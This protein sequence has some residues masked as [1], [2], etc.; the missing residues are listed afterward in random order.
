MHGILLDIDGT[1]LL[2][3]DPLPGAHE[4][5]RWLRDESRP[6]CWLTNNTSMSRRGWLERLAAAGLDPQPNEVYTAGDATIDHLLSR[7]PV[8]RVYL[9]GTDDLRADFDAAAIPLDEE[10]P[11]VVVLGYDTSLTYAKL[12]R[13]GLLLGQGV[14]FLATHPDVTCPTPD[15]PVPDVGSFIALFGAA[16][17]RSPRVIGKPEPT[18]LRG[19]LGRLGVEP[20][21][22][23]MVGDRLS[24]DMRMANDAG[25]ASW[26]VLSGVTTAVADDVE[27]AER[28]QRV[29]PGLVEVRAALEGGA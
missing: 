27:R 23:V 3:P 14:E 13:A 25:A 19:A 17:G 20:R 12:A 2:G 22:A 11:D 29:F 1:T 10:D 18:M 5:V 7:D 4:L 15:G 26:L 21:Q 6:F 9:V 16:Y 8:P 24:T 28:P